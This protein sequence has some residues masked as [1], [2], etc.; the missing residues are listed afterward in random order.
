MVPLGA[1]VHVFPTLSTTD[2]IYIVIYVG[3]AVLYASF[4]V[5]VAQKFVLAFQLEVIERSKQEKEAEA[6]A[7]RLGLPSPK[8]AAKG[9][10]KAAKGGRGRGN[11]GGRARGGGKAAR[12][13]RGRGDVDVDEPSGPIL[14]LPNKEGATEEV[15]DETQAIMFS[16][17]DVDEYSK[18][19][20]QA[21]VKTMEYRLSADFARKEQDR[22]DTMNREM[23]PVVN[24]SLLREL[25][26][27]T[28]P[29][30]SSASSRGLGIGYDQSGFSGLGLGSGG[31][32]PHAARMMRGPSMNW[33]DRLDDSVMPQLPPGGAGN[34]PPRHDLS[35]L[36]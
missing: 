14:A 8:A 10:S 32:S 20:M 16:R 12:G 33:R 23:V 11:A 5:W 17:S 35:R 30:V 21:V 6:E 31:S 19:T 1:K 7:A 2:Q 18:A 22:Y 4:S 3:V 15:D 28:M 9:S 25:E 36:V 24:P 13:G 26:S 27:I 34:S 29:P